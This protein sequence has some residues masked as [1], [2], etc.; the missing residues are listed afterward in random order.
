[1]V[2]RLAAAGGFSRTVLD[3]MERVPRHLFVSEALRFRAYEDVSLPIGH[4]QTITKPT[5][6]ARMVQALDLRGGER[7]LEIGTGSGYQAAVLSE[8]AGH[9]DT[10]ERIGELYARAR[11]TLLFDLGRTNV[12]LVH[13]GDF[14]SPG[15][16][17]DGII[18]A[19]VAQDLPDGLFDVLVDGGSLV[20]PVAGNRGQSIRRYVKSNG[21][22]FED[23]LGRARF[24][25]LVS[26]M[27]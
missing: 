25:P 17:Y 3:A 9:V 6:V 16:P 19:A 26:P 11:D 21:R 12:T 1:M 18:V 4:G 2:D 27:R 23:E 5:T 8:L 7:V 24:V 10:C 14:S 20:I 15:G 13:S 22:L